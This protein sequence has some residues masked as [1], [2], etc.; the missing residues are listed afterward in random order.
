MFRLPVPIDS[1]DW[2]AVRT[3]LETRHAELLIE[4]SDPSTD[5]RARFGAA[6]RADEIRSLMSAPEAML[7]ESLGRVAGEATKRNVY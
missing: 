7:E 5:D 2:R 3:A 1:P 6:C 4:C